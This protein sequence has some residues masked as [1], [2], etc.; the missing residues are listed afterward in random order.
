[1]YTKKGVAIGAA[2]WIAGVLAVVFAGS[3]ERFAN[4][5]FFHIAG[6]WV[7]GISAVLIAYFYSQREIERR[8]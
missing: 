7:V 4:L 1:M 5:G 3:L 6:G 2:A 8:G